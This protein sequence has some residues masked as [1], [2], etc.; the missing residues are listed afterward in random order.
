MGGDITVQSTFGVGTSLRF[1][2]RLPVAPE[3]PG[4]G[5]LLAAESA[6]STVTQARGRSALLAEDDD[7]NALIAAAYLERFGVAVDRVAN[8]AEAVEAALKRGARPDLVLMDCRMPV[9][10]GY[11]ATRRIRAG[12][13][14]GGLP[15][16]PVI[17][18]TATAG[19]DDRRLCLDAGMDDFLAKPYSGDELVN[20]VDQWLQRQAHAGGSG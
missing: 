15:R 3:P 9:M 11:E 5:A 19:D 1:V 17:A 2:A 14:E 4:G 8:G 12:E 10:D 6:G 20:L 18:L 13:T 7:V 16:L